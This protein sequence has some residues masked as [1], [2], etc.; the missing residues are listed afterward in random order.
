MR[1]FTEQISRKPDYYPWTKDFIEA[2]WSGHWTPRKF[3]FKSDIHDFKTILTSEEQE[4]IVRTLTAIGQ[5]EIAVKKFW[6]RLGD[7]LPHPSITDMGLVMA[8]I[9][10]T[11]GLAYEKLLMVLGLQGRFEENLKIPVIDG[12]VKYLKKYLDKQYKDNRKQYIY[13]LIL[14]TLFVENVSLFSQF[15][16]ILWF[17]RYRN[18][19]KDTNNQVNYTKNEELIH[20][21]M[22]T[23]LINTI[24]EECPELFDQELEDKVIQEANEALKAES[25]IID[26][27]LGDFEDQ[28]INSHILKEFVKYRIGTSLK[29]IGFSDEHYKINENDYRDIEW[30]IEEVIG[31]V[32]TDFFHADDVNY[33][34]DSRV[35]NESELFDD[36]K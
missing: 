22:G 18:V 11:H 8:S 34:K 33:S 30:F 32:K 10:V 26:W 6:S 2:I 4:I 17:G 35:I 16:V 21:E 25:K 24:R 12:R 14:F 20:G 5:I 13:S 36:A 31:E 15:Y 23:K 27:I 9:E 1:I 3:S 29:S 7:N 28:R 19:L